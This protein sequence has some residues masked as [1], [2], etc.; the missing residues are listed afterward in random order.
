VGPEEFQ[1]ALITVLV[2]GTIVMA[3]G[4][5]AVVLMLRGFEKKAG[6]TRHIAVVAGLL[7]FILL[8]CGALFALSY[9]EGR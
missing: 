1:R 3:V 8:C 6:S 7:G 5:T 9:L 4:T 2:V